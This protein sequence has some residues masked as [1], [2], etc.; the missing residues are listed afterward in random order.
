MRLLFLQIRLPLR[1]IFLRK[2]PMIPR[3][4]TPGR[5]VMN[6]LLA[7]T[8]K[9]VTGCQLIKCKLVLYC[10]VNTNEPTNFRLSTVHVGTGNTRYPTSGKWKVTKGTKNDA[11]AILFQLEPDSVGE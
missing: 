8:G 6:P 9:P 7:L 5:P 2:W 10:D 4:F 1:E 3:S 11:K